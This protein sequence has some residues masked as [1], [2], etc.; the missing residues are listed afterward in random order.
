MAEIVRLD[1]VLTFLERI[2][3]DALPKNRKRKTPD[4]CIRM[5]PPSLNSAK[6]LLAKSSEKGHGD[7]NDV[8]LYS[9]SFDFH[10][11]Y[12]FLGVR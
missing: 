6:A 11:Y 3:H 4:A 12:N 9:F 7:E 5:R 2:S 8:A 1:W 10:V